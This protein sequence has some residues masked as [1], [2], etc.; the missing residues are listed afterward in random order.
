MG[1][2]ICSAWEGHPCSSRITDQRCGQT[3]PPFACCSLS[4]YL[5]TQ[6]LGGYNLSQESLEGKAWHMLNTHPKNVQEAA[7][8]TILLTLS[9]CS[10]SGLSQVTGTGRALGSD[11][12]CEGHSTLPTPSALGWCRQGH[13][14]HH[15]VQTVVRLGALRTPGLHHIQHL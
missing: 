2:S 5:R 1:G 14:D 12:P 11:H 8:P 3:H 10:D 9:S 7:L 6:S 15:P 13:W 4:S